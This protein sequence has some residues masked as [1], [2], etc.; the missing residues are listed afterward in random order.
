MVKPS[1]PV[2]VCPQYILYSI[3]ANNVHVIQTLYAGSPDAHIL[4][5]CLG[6]SSSL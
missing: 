5:Y 2:C 1:V 6:I 3:A 4:S